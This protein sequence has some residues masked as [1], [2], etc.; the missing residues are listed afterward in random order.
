MSITSGVIAAAATLTMVT[1]L[2]AVETLSASA[3]TTA[4]GSQCGSVFSRE[5]GTYAQPRVVEAVLQGRQTS[6]SL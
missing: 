4:C 1:A 6:A 2:S 5:L 3:A